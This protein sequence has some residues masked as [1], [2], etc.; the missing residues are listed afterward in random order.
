MSNEA[1]V[2]LITAI[3]EDVDLQLQFMAPEV[4]KD[5]LSFT[6]KARELGYNVDPEDVV[7]FVVEGDI[8]EFVDL[9]DEDLALITGGTGFNESQLM[10]S[11]VSLM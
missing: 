2:G 3:R 10:Q 9:S 1:L 5:A 4:M 11:Y 6:T 8:T 7:K